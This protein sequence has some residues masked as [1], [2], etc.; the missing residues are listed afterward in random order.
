[1]SRDYIFSPG[2][3]TDSPLIFA[4]RRLGAA[5]PCFDDD[6]WPLSAVACWV[7]ERTREAPNERLIDETKLL[8]TLNEIRL[9]LQQG[10]VISYGLYGPE[11]TVVEI[12]RETWFTYA[13]A[14][15]EVH[16]GV[17]FLVAAID[18]ADTTNTIRHLK[19][20]RFDVMR[21]WPVPGV[22]KSP[23]STVG[24]ERECSLWLR[25]LMRIAPGQPKSKSSMRAAAA[26]RYPSLSKRGFDRAWERAVEESGATAWSRSGRRVAYPA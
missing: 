13:L 17:L 9:A 20:R 14:V 2:V 24:V 26:Q 22:T 15:G 1:M 6:L 5:L 7:Q 4:M 23:A 19:L 11:P 10:E 16:P 12:P 3:E 25:G 21:R 18:D 8:D